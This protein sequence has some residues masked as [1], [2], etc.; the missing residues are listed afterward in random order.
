MLVRGAALVQGLALVVI[1]ALSTVITGK[2]GLA[3]TTTQ[4][5][6]LFIPQTILAIAFSLGD[7]GLVTRLGARTGLTIGFA[8][9]AVAMSLFAATALLHDAREG[10]YAVLLVGAA[11]LGAGFAI[12]TPTLNVLAAELEPQKADRAI[13]FV[14]A[15]LGGS[16]VI[17]PLLSILFISLGSWWTLPLLCAVGMLSLCVATSRLPIDVKAASN[18]A[19]KARF[20]AR[21]WLF[22]TFA[23]AYGLCEQLNA[24]WAPLYM[25]GHLAANASLGLLALAFFWG[26]ATGARIVFALSS[27]T[28]KPPVVFCALPCV[29]AAAFCALASL[30]AH[31]PGWLGVAA[32]ALAGFGVSALLPLLLSFAERSMPAVATTV[33]SIVFASYLAGYGTAAF[34]VGPLQHVIAIASL[35]AWAVGLASIV[36]T[37]SILIVKTMGAGA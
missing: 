10:S 25:S 4:Y 21:L 7:G 35:D 14:N 12:V 27:A 15:L 36:A 30:P 22:I 31:A 29:L 23:F 28:L 13:L 8:A 16:A 18:S 37:L 1:P 5:G 20:P 2:S 6:T 32:F 33:T 24:S 9:N 3:L 11:F 34:G 17:A 19:S 26:T